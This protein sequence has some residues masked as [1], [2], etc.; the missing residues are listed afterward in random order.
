MC[1]VCKLDVPMNGAGCIAV[2]MI[3]DKFRRRYSFCGMSGKPVELVLVAAA[4]A[5]A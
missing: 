3:T 2:H 1:P 5:V 4:K